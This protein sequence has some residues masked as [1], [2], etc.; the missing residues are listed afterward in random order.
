MTDF[1][2]LNN[3]TAYA[4]GDVVDQANFFNPVRTN[5]ELLYL[6]NATGTARYTETD[7]AN[8]GAGTSRGDP[9]NMAWSS[10]FGTYI[11]IG[12]P[13]TAGG[14]QVIFQAGDGADVTV[15]ERTGGGLPSSMSTGSPPYNNVFAQLTTLDGDS[16]GAYLYKSTS[17]TSASSVTKDLDTWTTGHTGIPFLTTRTGPGFVRYGSGVPGSQRQVMIPGYHTTEAK[18]AIIS[19]AVFPGA[20]ATLLNPS[21]RYLSTA[22]TIRGI[23]TDGASVVAV[24]SNAGAM[25]NSTTPGTTV[26]DFTFTRPATLDGIVGV[27]YDP[28]RLLWVMF[29]YS[30]TS[31]EKRFYS[32]VSADGITWT[33]DWMGV[34]VPCET[35]SGDLIVHDS[36][37]T[38]DGTWFVAYSARFCDEFVL[39]LAISM[40]GGGNWHKR[41]LGRF[42]RDYY[43]DWEFARGGDSIL[44]QGIAQ[45]EDSKIIMHVQCGA[46]ST[47]AT[48]TSVAV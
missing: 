13:K 44:L 1:A 29:G 20:P 33:S 24:T 9:T 32:T 42:N 7:V 21:Y 38:R 22:E 12:V 41:T 11:S 18:T 34:L 28:I 6:L 19:L 39:H 4:N 48:I 16:V 46:I 35:S 27:E 8:V 5:E 10:L 14:D 15:Y 36:M 3:G 47:G 31:A 23:A 26:T 17:S 37:I 30:N 43:A 25:F 40:D 2:R 45:G